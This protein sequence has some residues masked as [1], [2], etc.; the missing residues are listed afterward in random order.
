MG[1]TILRF[2]HAAVETI[3]CQGGDNSIGALQGVIRIKTRSTT[4]RPRPVTEG[5][6]A[7]RCIMVCFGTMQSRTYISPT[8][9]APPNAPLGHFGV[10]AAALR[11]A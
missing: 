10:D 6:H 8:E 7:S 2:V 5:G 11:R 3:V 9:I 4:Y 1:K